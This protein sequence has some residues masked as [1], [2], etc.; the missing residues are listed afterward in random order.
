MVHRRGWG[1]ADVARHLV[2]LHQRRSR[3]PVG[4]GF[5]LSVADRRRFAQILDHE[6]E[7]VDDLLRHVGAIGGDRPGVAQPDQSAVDHAHMRPF[8]RAQDMLWIDGGGEFEALGD[9][10]LAAADALLAGGVHQVVVQA[11][12]V[13]IRK[14]TALK[15]PQTRLPHAPAARRAP[16][17]GCNGSPGIL[18]GC[19]A[20]A[21]GSA[22]TIAVGCEGPRRQL[23]Q[24][25]LV[26]GA[27]QLR[28]ARTRRR[29]ARPPC[30]RRSWNSS[31]S[32]SFGFRTEN[33]L[34]SSRARCSEQ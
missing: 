2:R 23:D 1:A 11:L 14:Q 19:I 21:R 32:W 12:V 24:A 9:V 8:L 29:I 30:D 10:E 6:V 33:R 31:E 17:S 18:A 15:D 26:Q 22:A 28:S 3:R 25:A 20:V 5:Q 34:R 13:R 4:R 7:S 16:L 27:G